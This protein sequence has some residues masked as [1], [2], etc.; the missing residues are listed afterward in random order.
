MV[1]YDLPVLIIVFNNHALGMLRQWQNVF[2][3]EH[4]YETGLDNRGPDFIKLAE[5]YGITG[6]RVT[7]EGSFLE[8]LKK[9]SDLVKNGKPALIEAIIDKDE[10][11]IPMPFSS[12][13][14]VP[15]KISLPQ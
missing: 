2:F 11:V 14:T 10:K 5:A 13:S 3:S 15:L 4:Y 1:K 12:D 7:D 8:A 6:Y 9:G